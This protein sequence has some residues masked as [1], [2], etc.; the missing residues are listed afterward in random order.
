MVQSGFGERFPTRAAR[1]V[2]LLARNVKR[3][4]KVRN[5][6]QED[7]AAAAEMEQQAISLIENARA[8]P[9]L[10]ALNAIASALHAQMAD[11][12]DAKPRTERLDRRRQTGRTP[13]TSQAKTKPLGC[14]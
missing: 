1:A 2:Q 14:R 8:N 5:L 9:T 10:L 12:F 6:T 11:L 13:R 7:L 3:L 4:R